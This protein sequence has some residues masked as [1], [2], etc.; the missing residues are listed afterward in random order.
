MSKIPIS[1]CIIAKDEE[2]RIDRCLSSL[3][4]YGFEIVVVDTGSTDMTKVIASK[5]TDCI[6]DFAWTNDFSAA[7]NYSLRMASNN[8]IFMIDCDEWIES[9]DL[10]ELD[11]FRKNLSNAVG[12]VKRQNITNTPEDPVMYT[13]R[14]ERFFSRKMYHYTGMIHEQLTPKHAFEFESFLLKTVIGHDGYCM[15]DRERYEKVQR[16]L[17]MLFSQLE[18]EPDNPYVY[19]QIGRTYY[20]IND[21]PKACFFYERVF[22]FDLNPQLNYINV[23][24]VEYAYSLIETRQKEKAL[25]LRDKYDVFSTT[26]DFVYVMGLIYLENGLYEDA[27]DEFLKAAAFD[28]SRLPG[29]N[30]FLPNYKIGCILKQAGENEM[31]VKYFRLCGNYAPALK[32]LDALGEPI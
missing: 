23:M 22:E 4:P 1:V 15:S 26:A 24:A 16:N 7:R 13:D 25:A 14:T 9:I 21:Y 20:N 2:S 27:L 28:T 10:E 11:Y 5:Y 31:A 19:F 8:W 6:Y 3:A 17:K 32:E 29:A 12:T 18:K 30:S